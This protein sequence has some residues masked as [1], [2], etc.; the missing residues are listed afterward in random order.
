MTF[1]FT[2]ISSIMKETT[3]H[4]INFKLIDLGF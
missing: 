2:S 4:T 1:D 3:I